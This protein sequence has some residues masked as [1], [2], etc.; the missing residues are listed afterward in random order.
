MLKNAKRFEYRNYSVP[1]Y[2]PLHAKN[3][4]QLVK[5]LRD[6]IRPANAVLIICGMYV[7]HREWIQKEIDIAREMKKPIIGISPHGAER[8][9]Q[10]I[11][12]IAPIISWRTVKIVDAIRHSNNLKAEQLEHKQSPSEPSLSQRNNELTNSPDF[13]TLRDWV[14]DS[15]FYS[16]ETDKKRIANLERRR[17]MSG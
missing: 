1:K 14:D 15:N 13:K 7:K 9:P 12:D 6:Q 10:E 8:I 5:E 16:P 17:G 3:K 2:D 11:Q 4:K